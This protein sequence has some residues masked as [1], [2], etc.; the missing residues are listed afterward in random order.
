MTVNKSEILADSLEVLLRERALL[1]SIIREEAFPAAL[2][3]ATAVRKG[4][5][6]AEWVSAG[7]GR[8]RAVMASSG[9]DHYRECARFMT[10]Y[11]IH[12][13]QSDRTARDWWLRSLEMGEP[14]ERPFAPRGV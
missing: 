8:W 11:G 6:D 4:S 3:Y 2:E 9:R 1:E 10:T 5:L 7:R 14:D 13:E 12:P